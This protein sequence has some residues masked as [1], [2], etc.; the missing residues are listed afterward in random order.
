MLYL[1]NFK[2]SLEMVLISGV[3]VGEQV[4]RVFLVRSDWRISGVG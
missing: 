4:Q 3:E 2:I 1:Q